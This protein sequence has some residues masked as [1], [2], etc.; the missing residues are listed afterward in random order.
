M[1]GREKEVRKST[2][3]SGSRGTLM[4]IVSLLRRN[5]PTAENVARKKKLV[6]EKK[7][8]GETAQLPLHR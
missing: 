2:T 5:F 6:E 1:E 3:L 7:A 8:R 4:T